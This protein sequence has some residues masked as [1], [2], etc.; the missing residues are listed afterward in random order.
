M[1]IN[2]GSL[3]PVSSKPTS[4]TP[5]FSNLYPQ[6]FQPEKERFQKLQSMGNL[7]GGIELLPSEENQ[8][9]YWC[10]AI[11]IINILFLANLK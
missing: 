3:A 10:L 1:N 5:S 4:H 9:I 6:F 8:D 11:V 2:D 7:H